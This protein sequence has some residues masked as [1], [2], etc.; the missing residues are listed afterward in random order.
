MLFLERKSLNYAVDREGRTKLLQE[1]QEQNLSPLIRSTRNRCF[2]AV[3]GDSE[4]T[5]EMETAIASWTEV[6]N[7][8]PFVPGDVFCFSDYVLFLVFE[9]EDERGALIGAG[10]IFEA[11]TPEPF[12]TLDS[13]CATV[14]DLLFT[15]FQKQGN[16]NADFPQWEPGKQDVPEG[17]RAFIARQDGDSLYTSLRKET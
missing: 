5:G 10:I 13:F 1:L 12:R 6:A 15:Q 11:K 14:R 16:A 8:E 7:G 2:E 17:F 9:D 3:L 4:R